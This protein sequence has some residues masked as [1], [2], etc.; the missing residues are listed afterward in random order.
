MHST[1]LALETNGLK[2]TQLQ[3]AMTFRSTISETPSTEIIA[4][5]CWSV[6]FK[7]VFRG[8]CAI[9]PCWHKCSS[10]F[11]FQRVL[12]EKF[13]RQILLQ[14]CSKILENLRFCFSMPEICDIYIFL[15]LW[16]GCTRRKTTSN[17]S[18]ICPKC[19]IPSIDLLISFWVIKLV[20]T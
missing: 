10:V 12:Q 15:L 13:D 4:A 5:S 6:K 19:S 1:L 8:K 9:L 18:E 7:G 3:F 17:T 20:Y 2:L 16:P 14:F 11:I